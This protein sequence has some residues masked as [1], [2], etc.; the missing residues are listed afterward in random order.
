VKRP[1]SCTLAALAGLLAVAV[2]VQPT[3]SGGFPIVDGDQSGGS[4]IRF[5]DRTPDRIVITTP[6]YELV[7]GK[8]NGALVDLVDRK[9]GARLLEGQNGCLWGAIPASDAPPVTGCSYRPEGP[10][11]ISYRWDRKSSTLYLTYTFDATAERRA[12]AV[13]TIAA[14]STYFDIRLDLESH[15]GKTFST[16][17]FPA[18]LFEDA[19]AVE[20]GY[21][22]NYLPGIR[23]KPSFFQRPGNNVLM[24]PS[25]WAYADYLALDI[26]GSQLALYSVNPPPSPIAPVQLGFVRN[27]SPGPCSDTK[28]C[29]THGFETWIRDGE[30]WTSPVVRF[31]VGAPVAESILAYR[32]DN[33]IDAYPSLVDKLGDRLTALA[34]APLIKADLWKGLP[35]FNE[36]GAELRRLPSPALIHPVAFQP[37]GH[38]ENDPDFLPPD[39]RWGT[40]Q[41]LN[42]AIAQAHSL[43][44]LV[45]P[46][47]NISWW[48]RKAPTVEE[49]PPTLTLDDLAV[50]TSAGLPVFEQYGPHDGFLTSPYV[51]FVRDRIQRLMEEWRTDAP[52]DCLFFDQIGARPWRR[53]FNPAAPTPLAYADGWL[54]VMAPYRDRCLMVEDGWDRLADS[55]VGFHGSSMLQDREFDEP[56]KLWGE[57]TWEPYPLAL[58]LLHDK[59]LLYQHDLS[60]ATMT[61][62]PEVLLYNAAFGFM[63][64][65]SWDG[66]RETLDSPWLDLVG[67]VQ[68]TLGPLFAGRALTGYRDLA[69]GVTETSFGDYSVVANWSKTGS[70]QADG[71]T[72]APEGFLARTQ[73][74]SVVAGAFQGSF[75]GQPLSPGTHYLVVER[76][77]SMLSVSQPL[78]TDTAVSVAPP[79]PAAG[80]RAVALDSAGGEIAAVPGVLRDGRFEFEYRRALNGNPVA[81]YRVGA[82]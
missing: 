76:E 51:A 5:D 80:L 39:S 65:Y 26:A 81:S 75:A 62:D 20:A 9:T 19:E 66:F 50:Q 69:P 24:Y 45:M 53:D 48:D 30:R 61:A 16:V 22:P 34:Q 2:L 46:Y 63:L 36:W 78:G 43:K 35:P 41:D 8:R 4:G 1:T 15:W 7:V 77:G 25:R 67:K 55:F 3:P 73:D 32:K 14:S 31:R 21:A 54:A 79:A 59:V 27:G 68:R 29:V 60:E 28:F 72:L 64:S 13:A 49:L 47:L 11:R 56:N 12:N 33:K 37:R 57:G 52:V 10:S 58:W 38:D 42:G 17:L 40:M 23:F 6:A 44:Q 71:Y 18:D 74:G 82:G 70:F